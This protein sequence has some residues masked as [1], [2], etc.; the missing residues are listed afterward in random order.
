MRQSL[1]L[2]SWIMGSVFAA[3]VNA[4][5]I[6]VDLN[7]RGANDGTSW[8]NAFLGLQEAINVSVASDEIWIAEGVYTPGPP[9]SDRA[10]TFTVKNGLKL[11]GGF[12]TGGGDGTFEARDPD[13]LITTL[14]GDLNG[15]DTPEG[16]NIDDNTYHVVTAPLDVDESTVLDGFTVSGGNADGPLSSQKDGGGFNGHNSAATLQGC[17]FRR[18]RATSD[19]AAV[20]MEDGPGFICD[21]R[22]ELNSGTG[23]VSAAGG[24]RI[25]NCT[26]ADN[27][28]GALG[29]FQGQNVADDCL[30]VNNGQ[31]D[32]SVIASGGDDGDNTIARCII[33]GNSAGLDSGAVVV[34]DGTLTIVDCLLGNNGLS[35]T[36]TVFDGHVNVVN[37]TLVHGTL[38]AV[39]L[40][41]GNGDAEVTNSILWDNQEVDDQVYIDPFARGAITINYSTLQNWDGSLGGVGNNGDDP[42]FV[43][44][45]GA[46]DIPGNEDDNLH[47][48]SDS[49]LIDSGDNTAVPADEFDLDGDGDVQEPIP[50]DLDGT[51][52]FVDDP[53]TADTGVGSPPIVDRGAYEFQVTPP[54]CEGDANADGV[55][56][57]LDAGYVLARFGCLVGTGDPACDAADVNDDGVV[58][59]LDVG[60][61]LSRFGNTCP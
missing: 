27:T 46:D 15:N 36:V 20:L 44:A 61:V 18:N 37:S 11:Y 42:L 55:V 21:C 51:P 25:P 52:R 57:P 50:V 1:F 4:T 6:H 28:D 59:P 32:G 58:D 2:M 17:I 30:F 43:D 54:P 22:F 29:L 23:A 14:S 7:A 34:F 26:F 13:T 41:A 33:A 39:G 45:D 38:W 40:A 10:V 49:P 5:V 60:F 48:S 3:V 53:D 31:S 19:G 56:D 35:P 47:L 12:P 8:R 16:E 9:G 24:V